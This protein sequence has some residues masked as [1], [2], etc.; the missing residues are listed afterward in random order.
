LHGLSRQEIFRE[1]FQE[2]RQYM[3]TM[4]VRDCH[5][6]DAPGAWSRELGFAAKGWISVSAEPK[7]HVS[8]DPAPFFSQN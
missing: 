2:F 8:A 7:T 4:R 3:E 5:T 6:F 1:V